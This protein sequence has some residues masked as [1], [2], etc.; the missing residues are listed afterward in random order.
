MVRSLSVSGVLVFVTDLVIFCFLGLI[1]LCGLF[2][3]TVL[4]GEG[5]VGLTLSFLC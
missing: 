1:Y 5:Q 2:T 3:I 4:S